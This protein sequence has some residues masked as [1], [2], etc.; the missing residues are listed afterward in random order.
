MLPLSPCSAGC[1]PSH[2]PLGRRGALEQV[3]REI[4]I[5]AGMDLFADDP[6]AAQIDDQVQVE[7][8]TPYLCGQV[9]H[10]PAPDHYERGGDMRGGPTR[11]LRGPVTTTEAVLSMFAQQA[12]EARFTGQIQALIGQSRHDASPVARQRVSGLPTNPY[13]WSSNS[14]QS[15]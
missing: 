5:I 13:M 6:S 3:G 12:Q 7:P 10:I 14:P 1:R 4:G 9:G 2:A 15:W 11:P 8:L